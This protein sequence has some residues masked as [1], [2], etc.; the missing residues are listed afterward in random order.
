MPFDPNYGTLSDDDLLSMGRAAGYFPED[1]G[2]ALENPQDTGTR[3][4]FREWVPAQ[5]E[6]IPTQSDAYYTDME[7]PLSKTSQS[8]GVNQ[9]QRGHS[10]EKYR[11]VSGTEGD[12]QR[13]LTGADAQA[14]AG[15]TS[16]PGPRRRTVTR[17]AS[18][19]LAA[20]SS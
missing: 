3:A 7:A 20:V 14:R 15:M 19:L 9:S 4:D 11:Q 6:A 16:P 12:L 18:G 1:P 13:D 2:Q 5:Q 10:T 8:F 17:R